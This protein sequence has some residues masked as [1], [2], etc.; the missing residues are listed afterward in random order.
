MQNRALYA[1]QRVLTLSISIGGVLNV[2]S[3]S[4]LSQIGTEGRVGT[5]AIGTGGSETAN[6]A[7]Q[8]EQ[9]WQP[10]SSPTQTP[11]ALPNAQTNT[12]AKSTPSSISSAIAVEETV[13][14]GTLPQL[15]ASS[16]QRAA[17]LIESE[18][19]AQ[20]VTQRNLTE[21]EALLEESARDQP[22]LE[23]TSAEE[24]LPGVELPTKSST[25]AVTTQQAEAIALETT[26]LDTVTSKKMALLESAAPV[27][28]SDRTSF[29]F[30]TA[31][32]D[33]V[34][35]TDRVLDDDLGTLRLQQTRSREDEDL[36]VLRLLQ[37]T[38][39]P[40][41]PPNPKL[42]I[43]FLGGRLGF[44]NTDNAFRTETAIEEQIYQSGLTLYLFPRLSENTNLYAIAGTS[45]ARYEIDYNEVEVQ[46]GIR[47]RLFRRTFV[48]VGWRNQKLYTPGYRERLLGVNY[49][50]AMVSHRRILSKRAWVDGFYQLRLGFADPANASRLRQT[51]I[52][53]VNY[54]PTPNLRTSLLYQLEFDDYLQ[55][56]RFDI[57]H[58]FLGVISYNIT[59][60]SRLSLFG[61]TR[62]GNSSAP[63]VNLD[64]IFYGAGLNVNIPLF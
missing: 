2:L 61:G 34:A 47:H 31:S 26:F 64:D 10:Q 43:A 50:D 52:S 16:C 30:D 36:G 25:S 48:Q 23:E 4:A 53:S 41:P 38:Q 7:I 63:R 49:L 8:S 29:P 14:E 44:L 21:L 24:A 13:V 9:V 1:C 40:P 18:L 15:S 35:Q 42:P 62:L 20:L 37:T 19:A 32:E 28:T 17:C 27:S 3:V 59:P 45:L 22:R 58:Q 11:P 51:L 55:I 56:D 39:A 46:A 12:Q 6:W 60:E 57:S 33:L 54:A 5:E